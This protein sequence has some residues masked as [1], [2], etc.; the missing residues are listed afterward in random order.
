MVR[1]IIQINEEV[2]TGCG[3]MEQ[4]VTR[5]IQTSGKDIPCSVV[6]ISADGKRLNG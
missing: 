2:C 4:A 3:G 5:A 6:I 1:R